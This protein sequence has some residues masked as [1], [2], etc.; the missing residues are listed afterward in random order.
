[1]FTNI[2]WNLC[3]IVNLLWISTSN[4]PT[5]SGPVDCWRQTHM[6]LGFVARSQMFVGD[7]LPCRIYL[8][9]SKMRPLIFEIWG[10]LIWNIVVIWDVFRFLVATCVLI[11]MVLI[12]DP[13]IARKLAIVLLSDLFSIRGKPFPELEA[14]LF[15]WRNEPGNSWD[16]SMFGAVCHVESWKES[17]QVW[18]SGR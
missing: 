1:M 15:A 9:Q 4:K 13:R 8:C 12:I 2:V 16:R 10:I 14:A 18:R 3:N 5:S 11:D 6:A 7:P 17:A